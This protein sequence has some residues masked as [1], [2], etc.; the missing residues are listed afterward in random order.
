MTQSISVI[1]WWKELE[2]RHDQSY[3]SRADDG[4]D[5]IERAIQNDSGHILPVHQNALL[6]E[7][8]TCLVWENDFRAAARYCFGQLERVVIAIH[9][10]VIN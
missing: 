2:H 8:E 3:E 9:T 6:Y 10:I 7:F 1:K 4:P 5:T